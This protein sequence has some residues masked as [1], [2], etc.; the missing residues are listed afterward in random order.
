MSS[1]CT[2]PGSARISVTITEFNAIGSRQSCSRADIELTD[3]GDGAVSQARIN[4]PIVVSAEAYLNFDVHSGRDDGYSY[5]PI[6]IGFR[7]TAIMEAK[8]MT[9][10]NSEKHDSRDP[11]GRAAFPMRKFV[12]RGDTA[13]LT[14]LDTNPERAIF[15]FS[16]IVQRSD[17][18][19]GIIDPGIENRGVMK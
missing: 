1:D 7:D 8:E 14:L 6:G 2:Q 5:F 19:L 18:L 16:L 12:S 13:Q 9:R 3:T 15:D 11:L 17:G 4:D 10:H